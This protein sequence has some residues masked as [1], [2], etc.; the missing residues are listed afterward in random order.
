M[1]SQLYPHHDRPQLL[2]AECLVRGLRSEELVGAGAQERDH[3]AT[4]EEHVPIG[5]AEEICPAGKIG[6]I[7]KECAEIVLPCRFSDPLLNYSLTEKHLR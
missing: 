4:N 6:R 2:W 3:A 1:A 7:P 5:S